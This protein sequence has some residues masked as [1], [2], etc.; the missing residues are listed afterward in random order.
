MNDYGLSVLSQYGLTAKSVARGRGL[1][2]CDT[3]EG[4]RAIS[5]WRG[6]EAKLQIQHDIQQ[7]CRDEGFPYVDQVIKNQEEKVLSKDDEENIYL[8]RNWFLG[9]ECDT[10]SGDEILEC[11]ETMSRL[12]Q[13]LHME[14]GET[15][16]STDLVEECTRHNR[17][18]RKI[19]KYIQKKKKKNEFEEV[20]AGS[21]SQFLEQ[22]EKAVEGME[23]EG[24]HQLLEENSGQ[25]CHGE[26]T[27]HNFLF[28]REGIAVTNFEHWNWGLQIADL[29]QLMRKILEKHQWDIDFGREMIASYQNIRKLS[30]SELK[31]LILLLSY[32]WKY[33][34]IAN[35]YANSNKVWI[36]PKNVEKLKKTISLWEPWS[37]FLA[38]SLTK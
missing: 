7:H 8:V 30:Q 29:S 13:V 4:V 33:W 11:V 37:D 3:E 25:I 35:F 1:L 36:S 16:H 14:K 12:H 22:G 28:I 6:S 18:L 17:E 2:I 23:Q 34:K 32:P 19:K 20:M 10:R 5:P 24:Y 26:C 31:N 9:K 27:Q 21:I 15:I 38:K